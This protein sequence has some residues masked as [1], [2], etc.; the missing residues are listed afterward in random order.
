MFLGLQALEYTPVTQTPRFLQTSVSQRNSHVSSQVLHR[1]LKY[2]D[3]CISFFLSLLHSFSFSSFLPLPL[4]L[5]HFYLLHQFPLRDL[6]LS[7]LLKAPTVSLN[8]PFLSSWAI[9]EFWLKGDN[10]RKA[11][12]FGLRQLRGRP[13]EGSLP[14]GPPITPRHRAPDEGFSLMAFGGK[15]EML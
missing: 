4:F 6:L 1:R 5:P 13:S 12:P 14:R 11:P 15:Q 3:S 9:L 10:E 7:S 2:S 8:P